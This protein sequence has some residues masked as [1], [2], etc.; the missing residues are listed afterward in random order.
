MQFDKVVPCN[1]QVEQN[2]AH[3]TPAKPLPTNNLQVSPHLLIS[4]DDS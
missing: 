3:R 4:G 2:K 1:V